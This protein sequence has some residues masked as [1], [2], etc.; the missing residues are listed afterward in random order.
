MKIHVTT[1]N[2]VFCENAS[3]ATLIREPGCVNKFVFC[4]R[5]TKCI[6]TYSLWETKLIS[7][8]TNFVL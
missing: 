3:C 2:F 1:Q 6:K 5:A 7:S 8:S 4:V